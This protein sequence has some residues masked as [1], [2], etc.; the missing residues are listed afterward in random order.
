MVTPTSIPSVPNFDKVSGFTPTFTPKVSVSSTIAYATKS[1]LYTRDLGASISI[2]DTNTYKEISPTEVKEI[3]IPETKISTKLSGT[4]API[5]LCGETC[6]EVVFNPGSPCDMTWDEGCPGINPPE[7]F[8]N[9]STLFEL[10]PVECKDPSTTITRT[11]DSAEGQM[12]ISPSVHN[13]PF[14]IP[15]HSND[16]PIL[17]CND[18]SEWMI[19]LPGGP[20]SNWGKCGRRNGRVRCPSTWPYM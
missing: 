12:T 7:G 6:A 18:G 10:C 9:Q 11:K 4:D 20:S 13:H 1:P 5:D 8:T 15:C 2:P 3:N 16:E 17:T 14:E 19:T